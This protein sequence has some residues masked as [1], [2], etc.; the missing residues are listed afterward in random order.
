MKKPYNDL[1]LQISNAIREKALE[2]PVF[3]ESGNG[4]VRIKAR[5]Y[6]KD[7]DDWFG[8]LGTFSDR[9]VDAPD[10]EHTFTIS[11][12]GSDTITGVYDGIK[13]KVNC[14]AYS[15]LK[16]AHCSYVNDQSIGLES[17]LGLGIDSFLNPLTEDN[18]YA[19]HYGAI[20]IEL[21][22]PALYKFVRG[23]SETSLKFCE[24]YICVSGASSED[25]RDCAFVAI[26]VIKDFINKYGNDN[27]IIKA[28]SYD[29]RGKICI[30]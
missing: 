19:D 3:K 25:D 15:A 4:V 9:G 7:A 28:P 30:Y 6:C 21:S 22:R 14:N 5:P 1:V 11:P 2:I 20:C 12:G 10:Y 18:G 16:I 24:I 17:G 8:G 26:D 27:F 13:Q 29:D 23:Y